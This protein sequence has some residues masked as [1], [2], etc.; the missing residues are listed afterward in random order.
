[1]VRTEGVKIVAIGKGLEPHDAYDT[2]VFAVGNR[3]FAALRELAA[4]SITEGVRGLIVEDAA[5]IV[6]CSDVD[7]IDIDDAVAL[8][9]AETWLADNE[10]QI[11]RRA[12]R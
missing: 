5:E 12:E 4:P 2:G 8:A 6:D 9:K 3:F 1:C 7:W 10:R 11:F